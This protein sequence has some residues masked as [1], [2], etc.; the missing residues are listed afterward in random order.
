MAATE[1]EV[2]FVD[3]KMEDDYKRLARSEHSEDKR[4]YQILT[5]IREELRKRWRSGKGITSR[6]AL[7]EYKRIHRVPNLSALKL[8]RHGTVIYSVSR[9]RIQ[10]LD[11]L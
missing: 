4:L 5:G 11:I 8:H 9:A 3:K 10:I 1:V 7:A 6:A 2:V